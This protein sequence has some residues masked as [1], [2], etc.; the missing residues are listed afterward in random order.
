MGDCGVIGVFDC[1][2]LGYGEVWGL[3][4]EE[5]GRGNVVL[6]VV[7]VFPDEEG[8]CGLDYVFTAEEDA[9]KAWCWESLDGSFFCQL[10]GEVG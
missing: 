10:E 7:R 2:A 8:G 9:N 5:R 3:A 1:V 6:G 4:F